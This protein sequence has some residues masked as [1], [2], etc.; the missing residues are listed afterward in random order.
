[1][2]G[3]MAVDPDKEEKVKVSLGAADKKKRGLKKGFLPEAENLG[4]KTPQEPGV[5]E[6]PSESLLKGS[7]NSSSPTIRLL[8][9]QCCDDK[10]LAPFWSE[11]PNAILQTAVERGI[12]IR[13][14]L[15]T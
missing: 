10:A 15:S 2:D 9:V 1:M 8:L 12:S 5:E 11:H 7:T 13:R 14:E 3:W 4:P 6:G